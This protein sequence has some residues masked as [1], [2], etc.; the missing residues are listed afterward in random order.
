MV[1]TTRTFDQNVT[2]ATGDP[3]LGEVGLTDGSATPVTINPGHSARI[4]VTFTAPATTGTV[5]G[6]LY[7]DDFDTGSLSANDIGSVPYR[8]T[9]ATPR[10]PHHHR[11]HGRHGRR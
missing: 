10:P 7:V 8:Y 3:Q 2:T 1:A 4:P 11:G 5:S 6:D 9:V